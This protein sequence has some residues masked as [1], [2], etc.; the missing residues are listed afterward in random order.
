MN[1]NKLFLA[2][3]A[4]MAA[5]ALTKDQQQAIYEPLQEVITAEAEIVTSLNTWL[6]P[7]SADQYLY[8]LNAAEIRYGLPENLLVR[9]A[10]QESHFRDDIV[11]GSI[12]SSAGAQGIMQIVP[13][14]H[15]NVDPLDVSAA[16]D[17]AGKYLASLKR[18]TGTWT[19]A[20]A[21]YNWGIGNLKNKGFENA[22]TETKNYVLQIAGDVLGG[23]A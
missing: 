5:A 22:P 9:V 1:L 16:I 17:Y 3:A 10:Y 12:S 20:L 6:P 21:A 23:Y 18:Q 14:W 7:A 4:G 8:R 15:P 2:L 13:R 11:S 19:E